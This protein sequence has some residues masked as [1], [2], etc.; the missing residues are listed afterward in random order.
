MTAQIIA[1]YSADGDVETSLTQAEFGELIAVLQN[2]ETCANAMKVELQ[3]RRYS[4]WT[5]DERETL[6]QIKRDAKSAAHAVYALFAA[7]AF[8]QKPTE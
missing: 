6:E 8:K 3:Q 1:L 5:K 4:P 2:V 7:E